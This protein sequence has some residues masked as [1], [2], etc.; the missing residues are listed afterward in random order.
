[1]EMAA[2]GSLSMRVYRL[3]TGRPEARRLSY[4]HE[5][6]ATLFSSIE[7]LMIVRRCRC[8]PRGLPGPS[9]LAPPLGSCCAYLSLNHDCKLIQEH[10]FHR[11]REENTFIKTVERDINRLSQAQE[12]HRGSPPTFSCARTNKIHICRTRM[13]DVI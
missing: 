11:L 5:W 7:E 1:M 8:I 12:N 10:Y 6:Q 4:A 13:T 9:E 2:W 3:Q